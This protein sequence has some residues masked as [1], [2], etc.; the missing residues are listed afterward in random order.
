MSKRA[1]FGFIYL[2][3]FLLLIIT[4]NYNV[5]TFKLTQD[6]QLLTLNL[7]DLE[8]SV[9]LKELKY[10]TETSL[11]KVYNYAETSLDMIRQSNIR[12][13]SNQDVMTR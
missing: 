2:I 13:F 10:Y 7:Q 1:I 11:D 6:L 4:L 9:E 12:V 5:R 8:R 3:S